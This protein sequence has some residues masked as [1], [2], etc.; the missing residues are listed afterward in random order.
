M[1]VYF[2]FFLSTLC[3]WR[4]THL[5]SAEDGPFNIIY[6]MRKK[7]GAGFLGSL[8]D[9]FYCLSIWVAIP[10]AVWQ[11]S[12]PSEMFLFWLAF[13]GAAC[14][15]ERATDKKDREPRPPEYLED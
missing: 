10:F 3:V 12:T 2:L 5:L 6:Y 11:G 1:S 7:A 9:C 15:L 4:I 8:L 14:L 13:S